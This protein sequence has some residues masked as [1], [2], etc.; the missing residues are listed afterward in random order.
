MA[1]PSGREDD[2]MS[3]IVAV[4]SRASTIAALS[5]LAVDNEVI[6]V[7]PSGD[8]E[9]ARIDHALDITPRGP[10]SARIVALAW[11]S[12]PG[13]NLLR[14]SPLDTSRRLWRTARRDQQLR[15]LVRSADVVVAA[16]RDA[17]FTVWKMTRKRA[18]GTSWAAAFGAT[19]ARFALGQS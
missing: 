11:R 7:G 4:V 8:A 10:L 19:A 5:G 15:S 9:A 17:I 18:Y 16:D 2:I 13:R 1:L 12:A 3:R 14:I 6:V